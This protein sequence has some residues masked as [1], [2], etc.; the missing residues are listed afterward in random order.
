MN[1]R[2]NESQIVNAYQYLCSC[3]S[4]RTIMNCCISKRENTVP[5]PPKTGFSNPKCFARALNDC[6]A[7]ITKEHFI[8]EAVLKLINTDGKAMKISG[9]RWLK[10]GEERRVSISSMSAHIL[11]KRHN[12]SL[13]LLDNIG[14]RFFQFV[15]GIN[16]QSDILLI[17][18]FEIE[19]WMLKLLCGQIASNWHSPFQGDWQPPLT[20]TNILFGEDKIIDGNGL[21]FLTGNIS[22]SFHQ[23]GSWLVAG[24][25]PHAINGLSF[26]IAGNWFL[27]VMGDINAETI[28]KFDQ[29]NIR[30]INRPECIFITTEPDQ[31]EVHFGGPPWK[32]TFYTRV[33][34]TTQ[35][36]IIVDRR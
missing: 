2:K 9:P 33:S 6:S 15:L 4:G 3:G 16:L 24:N 29:N 5:T 12:N 31:R 27:F 26:L 1:N 22:A 10:K 8:S 28:L 23:I 13:S 19:R 35:K 14:K 32:G 17:N 36:P 7:E 21:F 20:W 30:R 25:E 18:G 11:C 34:K